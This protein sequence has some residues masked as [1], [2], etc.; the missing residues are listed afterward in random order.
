MLPLE[1]SAPSVCGASQV[2]G[3]RPEK[4][5]WGMQRAGKDEGAWITGG[6]PVEMKSCHLSST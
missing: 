1:H 3:S 6:E 2:T 5:G 4:S